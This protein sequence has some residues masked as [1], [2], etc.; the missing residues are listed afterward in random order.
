MAMLQSSHLILFLF[1]ADAAARPPHGITGERA[2][3]ACSF[4]YVFDFYFSFFLL[5]C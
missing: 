3:P 4:S 1:A 5:C 2:I